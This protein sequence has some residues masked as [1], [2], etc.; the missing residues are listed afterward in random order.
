MSVAERNDITLGCAWIQPVDIKKI[1]V[2]R[3]SSVNKVRACK[4][5]EKHWEYTVD[6]VEV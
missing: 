1:L 4:E 5:L 3:V 6:S 2:C